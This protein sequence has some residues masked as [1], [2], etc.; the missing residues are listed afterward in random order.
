M[1]L[2]LLELASNKT[3]EYDPSTRARLEKLL[4]KTM[5]LRIKPI[6]PSISITPHADGLE[7]THKTP[8]HVDVSLTATIPAMIKISRDG[9]EEADLQ[10]GELEIVGDPIVGQRFAQI[11]ADLNIN[12][13]ALLADHLGESPAHFITTTAGHAKEFAQESQHR[14]KHFLT[15][16][17]KN[18]LEVIVEQEDVN[19]FLDDVD[20]LRA[21]T[22]RLIARLK[23]LQRHQ[24]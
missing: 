8:D 12:W 22:D 5:S 10:P 2:Q 21:D 9:M 14:F 7:F 11:I 18:D 13:E 4:G 20:T 19:H 24:A 3:L 15:D 16:L 23:R 1:L 6:E 17:L